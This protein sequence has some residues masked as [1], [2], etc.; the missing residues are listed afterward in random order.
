MNDAMTCCFVLSETKGGSK[1][2]YTVAGGLK[3]GV[4]AS[5]R[6]LLGGLGAGLWMR[7]R[8]GVAR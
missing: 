5:S 4:M 1:S 2:M 8:Q 6:V 7:N 3:L